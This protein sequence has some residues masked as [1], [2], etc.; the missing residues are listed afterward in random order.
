[1]GLALHLGGVHGKQAPAARPATRDARLSRQHKKFR[2]IH[3]KV[4]HIAPYFEKSRIS[5]QYLSKI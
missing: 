4:E 2:L 5:N 3:V 1:M